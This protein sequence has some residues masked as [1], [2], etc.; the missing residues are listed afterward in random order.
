M[1]Y[2]HFHNWSVHT[3]H[4]R[5]KGGRHYRAIR[6]RQRPWKVTAA[7][8]VV[9][10][11]AWFGWL[12]AS[13]M[14]AVSVFTRQV[15]DAL[16]ETE[17]TSSQPS[18]SSPA[19]N[20]TSRP[21]SLPAVAVTR[22]P[23]TATPP[24]TATNSPTPT[25]RPTATPKPT[26]DARERKAQ[27]TKEAITRVAELELMVHE[28]INAARRNVG[29]SPLIWREDLAELARAHSD[30]MTKRNYFS[31]D[32]PEG[33]DP[34]D[35]L[36]EAG[37]SCRSGFSYGI[38]ENIAIE[39]SLSNPSVTATEAVAGWIGSPGHRENLLGIQ[40]DATGIGASFG[41]WQ[42]YKAVYLTQVFC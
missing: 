34:T 27:A 9:I 10:A 13:Q 39:T 16:T 5:P 25:P 33:L 15:N 35:R 1:P 36:H 20:S 41:V 28:G 40:Y 29:R 2:T 32:T 12:Y 26:V 6:R 23:A 37:L 22:P 31:H 17:R 24:P 18:S 8:I 7:L 21:T 11:L 14:E 4:Q 38:A 30:D 42:G 19:L 3:H